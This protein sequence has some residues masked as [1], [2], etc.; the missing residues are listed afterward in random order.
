MGEKN[1]IKVEE[2]IVEVTEVT[3]EDETK[4]T[5]ELYDNEDDEE[6]SAKIEV[7]SMSNLFDRATNLIE[8]C[9]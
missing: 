3:S 6:P 1:D 9:A 7:N 2:E 4:W 5:A 8:S